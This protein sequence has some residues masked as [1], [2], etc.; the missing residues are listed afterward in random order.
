MNM[1]I[2]KEEFHLKTGINPHWL[3]GGAVVSHLPCF[4][5]R[6]FVT[7]AVDTPE[8]IEAYVKFASE[9]DDNDV[10]VFSVTE[11][12]GCWD[13]WKAYAKAHPRTFKVAEGGSI[14]G[15]YMCRMYIYTKPSKQRKFHPDNIAKW[16]PR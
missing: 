6:W 7:R 15:K 2:S 4:A 3:G 8:L 13:A 1:P 14:H 10:L 5:H 11:R 12:D 9:R 16:R